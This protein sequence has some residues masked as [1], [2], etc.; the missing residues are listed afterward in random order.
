MKKG[1]FSLGLVCFICFTLIVLLPS[2]KATP[3]EDF[4]DHFKKISHY[5]EEYDIGNI[6]YAQLMIYLSAERQDME[7][8]IGQK[9]FSS[10]KAQEVLG[11]PARSTKYIYSKKVGDMVKT[12]NANNAWEK[13][14][15]D[16]K[17]IRINFK[18]EP[19]LYYDE[20]NKQELLMTGLGLNL[21]Y[22][23]ASNSISLSEIKSSI[24]EIKSIAKTYSDNPEDSIALELSNKINE[25][26]NLLKSH[27]EQK[28]SEC[29]SIMQDIFGT[30]QKTKETILHQEAL[31]YEGDKFDIISNIEICQDCGENAWM[32]INTYMK[33]SY[34][35]YMGISSDKGSTIDY[36]NIDFKK[37]IKNTLNELSSTKDDKTAS[38]LL[39][40][41]NELQKKWEESLNMLAKDNSK[42]KM[43]NFTEIKENLFQEKK[44]FYI[45]LFSSYN[46][47]KYTFTRT[48]YSQIL[49]E[50]AAKPEICNNNID[51]NQNGQID[52]ADKMCE[53]NNCGEV[54]GVQ[55]ICQN[56][57]CQKIDNQESF[58]ENNQCKAYDPISCN[59]T[60]IFKGTDS[61][62]CPLEPICVQKA[63]ICTDPSQCGTTECIEGDHKKVNC[64]SGDGLVIAIC[65]HGKWISTGQA[66]SV[67]SNV[68]SE[69]QE[70][71]CNSKEDCTSD[72]VC[73][74][75]KCVL[76]PAS[77]TTEEKTEFTNNPTTEI[78]PAESTPLTGGVIG[79]I[80]SFTG[81]FISGFAT[82]DEK[83]VEN[84][85]DMQ[86][87]EDGQIL[88]R[89]ECMESKEGVG[90]SLKIES[91]GFF[92]DVANQ[93]ENSKE[94]DKCN[95]QYQNDLT[96]RKELE[97]SLNNDFAKWFFEEYITISAEEWDKRSKTMDDLYW[98]DINL[99][100]SLAS[101][102][103]CPNYNPN[104]FN[105]INMSYETS[106]GSINFWEEYKSANINGNKV[107]IISPYMGFWVYPSEETIKA[108]MNTIMSNEKFDPWDDSNGTILDKKAQY[109]FKSNKNIMNSLDSFI[110]KYG[111]DNKTNI[112]IV[113]KDYNTN[114][115][116]LAFYVQI[117]PEDIIL[118]KP[119]FPEKIP[120][121]DIYAEVD[122]N[123]L[124]SLMESVQKDTK[125][126]DIR[127]PEWD[128]EI[129]PSQLIKK[130]EVAI[131][132]FFKLRGFVNSAEVTPKSAKGDA[133]SFAT[134]VFAEV[135]S[136][137][138]EDTNDLSGIKTIEEN[139]TTDN[140]KLTGNIVYIQ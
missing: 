42:D 98:K 64:E 120:K 86:K 25:F 27:T 23:Q 106:Y 40:K 55:M 37:E 116:V 9:N 67:S 132:V 88:L 62:G 44:Q 13:V 85:N 121:E 70:P 128:K 104:A 7:E 99:V 47:E 81:F 60:V 140:S 21:E 46:P 90:S 17:K 130:G 10:Q 101:N 139:S 35:G 12:E 109:T 56:N 59:G 76:L 38:E 65:Q 131:S 34:G 4:Q 2:A 24:Q 36:S 97:K 72:Q 31:L 58:Q 112:K 115:D 41:L 20:E 18:L 93:K 16:G 82:E 33:D 39:N 51:D 87:S 122:F 73:S 129:H 49:A 68:S 126:F 61:N 53:H 54:D 52:C 137:S 110:S 83:K 15:Y 84:K 135:F 11:A 48:E 123:R 125:E 134:K 69:K 19:F 22:K 91:W 117:N 138:N 105:L 6:N 89:G 119:M 50:H 63:D 5:A 29:N 136:K 113:F 103:D 14:I 107:N 100:Q 133:I 32:Q 30:S 71:E 96:E 124:L 45:D 3:S 8:Y 77:Q 95:I 78:T 108:N 26:Q 66:C 114:Q 118:V 127:S 57:Q 79:A 28:S 74:N 102:K 94:D 92:S 75:G 80:K 111:K 43:Q 1:A